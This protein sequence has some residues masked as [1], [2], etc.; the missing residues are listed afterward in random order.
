MSTRSRSVAPMISGLGHV[1]LAQYSAPKV[2]ILSNSG[3]PSRDPFRIRMR[4]LSHAA[5]TE[6][7]VGIRITIPAMLVI[8]SPEK[9][10]QIINNG[11]SVLIL[12]K[13]KPLAREPT[14]DSAPQTTI[15]SENRD[16]LRD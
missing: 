13:E 15:A 11:T 2:L 1:R 10:S 6:T 4:V 14:T 8:V 16:Q 9:T 3:S 7:E 12:R 5:T